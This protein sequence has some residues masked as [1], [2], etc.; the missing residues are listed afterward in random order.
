MSFNCLCDNLE[1]L[2]D[3][4][5]P[6]ESLK[7]LFEEFCLLTEMD[8]LACNKLGGWAVADNRDSGVL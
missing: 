7:D 8:K 6:F 2:D 1:D 4:L 5:P 3:G